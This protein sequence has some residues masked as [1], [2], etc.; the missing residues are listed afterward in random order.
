MNSLPLTPPQQFRNLFSTLPRTLVC[1]RKFTN[2]SELEEGSLVA[3]EVRD[4]E[5]GLRVR[6]IRVLHRQARVD[7]VFR[8]KVGNSTGNGNLKVQDQKVAYS[9]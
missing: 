8:P 7:P 2:L 3:L 4:V 1:L 9:N 5:H 6:Q